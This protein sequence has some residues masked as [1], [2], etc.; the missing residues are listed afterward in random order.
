MRNSR[1][2]YD[3]W[4]AQLP[5]DEGTCTPWHRMVGESLVDS[6]LAAKTVLE[7]GCGRGGFA[8]WLAQKYPDVR[9]Y[10]A[11][12]SATAVAMGRSAAL[13]AGLHGID[14]YVADILALPWRDASFDTVISCETIE[15][16]ESPRRA[17]RE[18]AR[19]LRPGGRLLLTVPNYFSATGVHRKY[20]EIVRREIYRE[21]GQ[22]IN[23]FTMLPCIARWLREADMRVGLVRS[24]NHSIPWPGRPGVVIRALERAPF[25]FPWLGSNGLLVGVKREPRQT[26]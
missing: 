3:A 5:V 11:D 1:P 23:H 9:L 25:P 17:I 15:H 13:A 22:P 8:C 14:W 4:H 10:A 6:D 18:L 26:G 2:I 21:E 12:F 7:I 16:V 24:V 20:R 19:V